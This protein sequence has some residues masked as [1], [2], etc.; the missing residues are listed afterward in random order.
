MQIP[1]KIS[2]GQILLVLAIVAV[3]TVLLRPDRGADLHTRLQQRLVEAELGRAPAFYLAAGPR[4]AEPPSSEPLSR[5]LGELRSSDPQKRW[6]AADELAV[7][8]N[9]LAVEFVIDAMMDPE[10]TVR[11]CVMASALG[12]LRDPR[13]LGPLTEAAFDPRNRDLRLCAIES[14]GM[15]GDPRAVPRLIEALETRNMPVAAANAIARMG[16][17]RGVTPI[18]EAAADPDISLWMISALGELGSRKAL[19]YLSG[20]VQDK[21]STLRAAAVEAQWKIGQLAGDDPGAELAMTLVGDTDVKHRQWAAFRMGER[22]ETDSIPALL[23]ALSDTAADV[24][25]RAAAALVRIWISDA[26][27]GAPSA[28]GN[29]VSIDTG[30]Q[31]AEEV[32]NA[33]YRV[34]S[35]GAGLIDLGV[36]ISGAANRYVMAEIEGLVVSSGQITWAA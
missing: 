33:A 4:M 18:I 24:R 8:R 6:A 13:A 19:P 30:T 1:R 9:P 28:T 10:G 32:A 26:D 15:L 25:E 29:T 20:R 7:R 16:D 17:E 2:P 14:L 11:V 36:T 22:G 34:I 27:Y 3:G 35:N 5:V 12:Y 23:A 21:D 31:Y